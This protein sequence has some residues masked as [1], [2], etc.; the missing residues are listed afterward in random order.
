[1]RASYFEILPLQE[2]TGRLL[3]SIWCCQSWSVL[4]N[5]AL[6]DRQKCLL[7]DD[8][9]FNRSYWPKQPK[10]LTPKYEDSSS[11]SHPFLLVEMSHVLSNLLNLSAMYLA[12]PCLFQKSFLFPAPLDEVLGVPLTRNRHH[13]TMSSPWQQ[14]W[15]FQPEAWPF[16]SKSNICSTVEILKYLYRVYKI[17]LGHLKVSFSGLRTTLSCVTNSWQTSVNHGAGTV[18]HGLL[19]TKLFSHV[20]MKSRKQH[21]TGLVWWK[22]S[23]QKGQLICC[24]TSG[25]FCV[26]NL[27]QLVDTGVFRD[28]GS[29]NDFFPF[30]LDML[31][32]QNG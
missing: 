15:W 3:R 7:R 29:M 6:G 5:L 16:K 2:K 22:D 1:M 13:F 14:R 25:T 20:W 12:I 10:E 4:S 19:T 27:E 23:R 26:Q 21:C 32:V 17:C 18:H 28:V 24:C 9:C 11:R 30:T 8:Y 31:Q